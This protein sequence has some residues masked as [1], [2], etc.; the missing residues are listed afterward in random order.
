MGC[1]A[2]R[3]QDVDDEYSISLA[4]HISGIL[5]V[6][7]THFDV[8][9]YVLALRGEGCDIPEDLD[10]FA[11]DELKEKPFSF[12]RVHLL[13]VSQYRRTKGGPED[14][15]VD[16]APASTLPGPTPGSIRG[17]CSICDRDVYDTQPRQKVPG[18]D[19]YQHEACAISANAKKNAHAAAAAAAAEADAEATAIMAAA[20]DAR[21]E[22][23]AEAR[24]K[25]RAT[26]VE[27]QADAVQIA[28]TVQA[29]KAIEDHTTVHSAISESPS[30]SSQA[31]VGSHYP[32]SLPSAPKIKP[33]LPNGM[34]V[35]LSYQWDVQEQ[36]TEIKS[37]LNE[38]QVK[39]W[40]DIDGGMKS[41]IYDSVSPYAVAL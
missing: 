17:R 16:A 6:K 33:L 4:E 41:D 1:G 23:I 22:V 8:T 13:K 21:A 26:L 11:V 15:V 27:A 34:H 7:P 31:K 37:L 40:M 24:R 39:C 30:I 18:T 2:S 10:V 28:G 32:L 5:G 19:L 12:K 35:M 20:N 38:R 14:V 3:S 9:R 25:A 36:V 29:E